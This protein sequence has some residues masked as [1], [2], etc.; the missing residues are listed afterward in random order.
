MF[1]W[2]FGSP[3]AYN[4]YSHQVFKSWIWYAQLYG[5][6]YRTD[7]F[8]TVALMKTPSHPDFSLW[9]IIRSG[10]ILNIWYL[11]LA[12]WRRLV[13]YDELSKVHMLKHINLQN[14]WYLWMLGTK[15]EF[16]GQG[17]GGLLLQHID[18]EAANNSGKTYEYI[19]AT[20]PRSA[21]FYEKQGYKPLGFFSLPSGDPIECLGKEIGHVF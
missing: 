8:N 7:N 4:D 21:R 9:G 14:P 1:L 18:Y 12:G 20:T 13:D 10:M 17:L 6:V 16:Q 3:K 11:G 2:V 15:T 19:E 5:K